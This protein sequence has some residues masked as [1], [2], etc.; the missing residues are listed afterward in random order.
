MLKKHIFSVQQVIFNMIYGENSDLRIDSF[1]IS[2]SATTFLSK[3][4]QVI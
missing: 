4:E 2:V 1:P 3:W